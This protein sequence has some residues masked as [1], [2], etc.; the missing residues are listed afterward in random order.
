MRPKEGLGRRSIFVLVAALVTVSS[1][2]ATAYTL[3]RLRVEAVDHHF[4]DASMYALAFENH[5]AQTFN[6]I[7]LTFANIADKAGT[8]ATLAA[9]L[10]HAPYLRS[11]ALLDA[12][13]AIVASSDPRNVGARIVRDEFLPPIAEP[14]DILRVGPPWA[15]RDFHAGRPTTPEQP[16]DPGARSLIPVLRDMTIENN[17][18]ITLLASVNTDYFLNYYD[19]SLGGDA[20]VVELLR[21]DGMLLLSSD[22]KRKPGG[23]DV[24]DTN[25]SRIE[26]QEFGHFEGRL[27]DGR[28]VLTAYRASRNYPF[29]VVV[30]LDKEGSLSRWRHE[31]NRTLAVVSTVLIAVLALATLYFMR[32]ERAARQHDADVKQLRLRGAA[33]EASANAIIVTD[34]TGTIEWANPA[35]CALSG[36]TMD[37][38]IGHNPRD[39]VKSGTQAPEG[40]RDLWRTILAGEVWRGELINCRKDHT[41]YLEDQTITPVRDEGGAISHFIAVK[42]DI[43]ERK[44][45]EKRMEE[46]SRHLVVVQESA[47]RRLAGELHER[48]SPNLSAIGVNLDIITAAMLE[49]QSPILSARLDD[50]RAL[51]EDTTASIREISSDLRPPV[52]DYGGLLAALDSYVKQFHRRTSIAVRIDCARPAARLAPALESVLFRVVQE[53]L[54]NCA[55][56][57][58]ARSIVVALSLDGRPVVLTISDDGVGFDPDSLGKATHTSGLGILNMREMAEFAGGKFTIES[59][60]GK[61]TRIKVEI[62]SMEERA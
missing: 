41:T 62:H 1:V 23:R 56:H 11:L 42:Q 5:L 49:W 48:T 50:V 52:L 34:R 25:F 39:L 8:T 57:S 43:T 21:Y 28:A 17:A 19:R 30:H 51:I 9:A 14:R 36:Y 18:R 16:A 47:R 2:A 24:G 7:N 60:P 35:F 45:Y 13:D 40:Y 15:G 61:G 38:A 44:H 22:A 32:M 20:D 37:E 59:A 6:V 4:N 31:A 29:I 3:W 26:G 54:T 33:L 53:A 27:E 55:K 46:L 12:S 10:R 58:R